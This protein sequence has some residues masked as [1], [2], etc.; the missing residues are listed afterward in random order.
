LRVLKHQ[1][2]IKRY[3]NFHVDEIELTTL[4]LQKNPPTPIGGWGDIFIHPQHKN[5]P[6]DGRG[7]WKSF[8]PACRQGST[9]KGFALSSVAQPMTNV[10]LGD[11]AFYRL[12]NFQKVWFFV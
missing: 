4:L 6:K 3:W 8:R 12:K 11:I 1:S 2:D 7:C 5:L 9:F 10:T